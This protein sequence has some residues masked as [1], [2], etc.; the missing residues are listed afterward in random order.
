MADEF[1]RFWYAFV[2]PN[3]SDLEMLDVDGVY[4][5][6]VDPQLTHFAGASFEDICRAWLREQNRAGELVTRFGEIGRFWNKQ[7]EIDVA[8]LSKAMGN[9]PKGAIKLLGE[10]KFGHEPVGES[11]LAQLNDKISQIASEGTHE[12]YLFAREGFSESLKQSAREDK[13]LHLITADELYR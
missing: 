7:L 10:C 2:F 5:F 12:R 6:D 1:F 8:G 3:R 9:R 11:V 4:R 13:A